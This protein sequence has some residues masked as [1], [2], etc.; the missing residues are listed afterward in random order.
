MQRFGRPPAFESGPPV[1]LVHGAIENGKI[2]YSDSEKGFACYLARYG[3]DVF[4]GDLRGRGKSSPPISAQSRYGQ[5]EAITED[6]PNFIEE[7]KRRRGPV[8]QIWI[9]HSWGGVL[10]LS[11]L[12]RFPQFRSLVSKVVFFGTKRCVRVQNPEKWLKVDFFWK[13]YARILIQRYGYLPAKERGVGSDNET[14]LSH[15]HSKL[16][17]QPGPWIDPTDGFNYGEEIRK[18]ELPPSLFLAG[19]KDYSL[20]HPQDVR[21]TLL[22]TGS[23]RAEF[24]ILKG[25]G[26]IDMMVSPQAE[27]DHFPHVLKFIS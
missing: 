18:I 26:H 1:L 12:A 23:S 16:W 11:V 9:G 14:D 4:V 20:G 17:V 21:A 6:I 5:F 2:F 3:Y 10:L 13:F 7:I 24:K 8:P 22:E 27:F 19:S 15:L 25:Y